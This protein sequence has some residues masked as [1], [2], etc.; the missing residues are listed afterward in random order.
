MAGHLAGD[1][2]WAEPDGK[3]VDAA[4]PATRKLRIGFT[5]AADAIVYPHVAGVVR[6]VAKKLA[7]F[8]HDVTEGGPD[9]GPFRGPFQLIVV[10]GL[11]GLPIPDEAL[12]DPFNHIGLAFGHHLSAQDYVRA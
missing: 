2:Y 10:S 6:D 9:T 11:P 4:R 12:L 5:V 8:G 1:P 7:D 3:F